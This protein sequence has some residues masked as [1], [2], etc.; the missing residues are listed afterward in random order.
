MK[1][2]SST[3]FLSSMRRY[4]E[5]ETRRESLKAWIGNQRPISDTP[6]Q[7]GAPMPRAGPDEGDAAPGGAMVQSSLYPLARDALRSVLPP[8]MGEGWARDLTTIGD[9]AGTVTIQGDPPQA[10][11]L[12]KQVVD[13]LIPRWPSRGIGVNGSPNPSTTNIVRTLAKKASADGMEDGGA[14]LTPELRIV[15]LLLEKLFGIKVKIISLPDS[16]PDAEHAPAQSKDRSYPTGQRQGWGLEYTLHETH[17]ESEVTSFSAS[18]LIKTADG[19]EIRFSLDIRLS[20]EFLQQNYISLR[21]GDAVDP[22]IINFAGTAAQ[23]S[24]T[25]FAFDLDMDGIAEEI[26]DLLQ[27]RLR[28]LAEFAG[29]EIHVRPAL[30]GG[31]TI[32]VDGAFYQGVGEVTDEAVRALLMEVV[33]AWEKG[34]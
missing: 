15:K 11:A 22:L 27:E 2:A 19:K 6:S 4:A 8:F 10:T 24:Q 34:L 3:V 13:D 17:Y 9:Y 30:S 16:K 12:A 5:L 1:I 25:K 29:R 31:V 23:L 7:A 18:G 20:R 14:G 32:E 26:E 28:G 21:A 33:R